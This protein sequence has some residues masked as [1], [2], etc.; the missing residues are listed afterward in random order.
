MEMSR[1]KTED[2]EDSIN[3]ILVLSLVQRTAVQVTE[4]GGLTKVE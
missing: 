3:K 1:L 2:R 4:A